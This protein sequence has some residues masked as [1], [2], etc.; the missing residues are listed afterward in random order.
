MSECIQCIKVEK[1]KRSYK[2]GDWGMKGQW[3]TCDMK[4]EEKG[5][6]ERKEGCGE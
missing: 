5:A 4:A 3:N 1:I 2:K 6:W